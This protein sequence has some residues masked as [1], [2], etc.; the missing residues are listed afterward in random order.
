VRDIAKRDLWVGAVFH[1]WSQDIDESGAAYPAA[2]VEYSN[3]EIKSVFCERLK[4]LDSSD[5]CFPKAIT[6][7][8]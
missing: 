2:I 5:Y 7:N 8:A 3:G 6:E 1:L 4:M